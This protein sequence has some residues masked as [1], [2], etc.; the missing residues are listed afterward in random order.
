MILIV[1]HYNSGDMNNRVALFVNAAKRFAQNKKVATRRL[2]TDH[3]YPYPFE[4]INTRVHPGQYCYRETFREV[5]W[6]QSDKNTAWYLWRMFWAIWWYQ[7]FSDP[8]ALI[9]HHTFPDPSKW[10]DEELGIPPDQQGSYYDWL[11]KMGEEQ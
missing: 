10:T 6:H 7:L 1:S 3:I 2:Y 9:G 4:Y 8:G 11:E 5:P